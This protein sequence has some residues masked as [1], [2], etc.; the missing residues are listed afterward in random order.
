MASN[1]FPVPSVYAQR[2]DCAYPASEPLFFRKFVR[3][4]LICA[5]FIRAA[6]SHGEISASLPTQG[7]E[8]LSHTGHAATACRINRLR[9][10]NLKKH[11]H[12]TIIWRHVTR[13]VTPRCTFMYWTNHLPRSSADIC[14][15]FAVRLSPVST[16]VHS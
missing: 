14:N 2:G 5:P 1:P 9:Q 8:K 6:C 16:Y 13:R 10:M 3:T 4:G 11:P 15:H 7:R 12:E